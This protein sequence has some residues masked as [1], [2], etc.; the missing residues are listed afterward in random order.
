MIISKELCISEMRKDGYC[1]IVVRISH[2]NKK[3]LIKTAVFARESE[4]DS[5]LSCLNTSAAE[6][7]IKN[8]QIDSI[9]RRISGRIQ[10]FID[11]AIDSNFE[12]LITPYYADGYPDSHECIESQNIKG[13]INKP[14]SG[15]LSDF[16]QMKID[17]CMSLNTRRG[18]DT[19]KRYLMRSEDLNPQITD[20]DQEFTNRFLESIHR[21]Y[22]NSQAM[23]RFMISRYN[24][25]LS[26]AKEAGEISK[27]NKLSLPPYSALPTVRNLSDDEII[28]IFDAFSEKYRQDPGITETTTKALGLFVLDI[29]FQGLAPVD[30]ANLKVKSLKYCVMYNPKRLRNSGK[31]PEKK[32]KIRVVTIST[33]R[34]KTGRPVDIVAS[35]AGI[36]E[37]INKLTEGKAPDDYL[38]DCFDKNKIYSITQR[39]NRLANYFNR[40]AMYLNRGI[41]EYY[42]KYRLGTP[43]RVTFYFARHAFC[44]L[45]DSMDVP[46]H[47]IQLLVGHRS[48]VLETNYL[49]PISPWEQAMI[50]HKLLTGLLPSPD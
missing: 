7:A 34:K 31:H 11:S 37:F 41:K 21:D 2:N 28:N 13:Q 29:A 14:V 3:R 39:Q 47:I 49:R 38:I 45:V 26:I 5:D 12:Q 35:V 48:T 25:V 6:N 4:W 44:N 19:F 9:Y 42:R 30:I 18:Y 8:E 33:K 32:H 10:S 46:R 20:I 36:E 50:S 24:A 40:I 16:V 17:A 23:Q 43:R 1:P 22:S 15:Q 27:I